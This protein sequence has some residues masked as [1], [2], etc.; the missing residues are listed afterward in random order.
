MSGF[1]EPNLGVGDA[2]TDVKVNLKNELNI[3]TILRELGEFRAEA[4]R[5]IDRGE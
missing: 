3:E 5:R 2:L 4:N 1:T